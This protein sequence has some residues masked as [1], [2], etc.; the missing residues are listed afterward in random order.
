M[1]QTTFEDGSSMNQRPSLSSKRA[2]SETSL[3]ESLDAVDRSE[4]KHRVLI[5]LMIGLGIEV[6]MWFDGT[7]RKPAASNH[8]MMIGTAPVV[9]ATITLATI[10]L[11]NEMSKNT[12][13]ILRAIAKLNSKSKRPL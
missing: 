9:V 5:A 1:E 3:Y 4:W 11:R 13:T 7:L 6:T 12:Q 8:A 2:R 10:K